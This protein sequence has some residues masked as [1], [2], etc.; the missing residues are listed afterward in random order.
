MGE[1]R[2]I[3]NLLDKKNEQ[4]SPYLRCILSKNFGVLTIKV[5]VSRSDNNG[6]GPGRFKS[7]YQDFLKI[8]SGIGAYSAGRGAL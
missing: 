5:A 1:N 8:G 4:E 7:L 2:P 6:F 3:N